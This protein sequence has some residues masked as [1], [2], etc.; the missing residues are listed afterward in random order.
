MFLQY[1]TYQC[2]EIPDCMEVLG[3]YA[4]TS[5]F[6]LKTVYIPESVTVFGE[7]IFYETDNVTI[8]GIS[9]SEAEN[10]AAQYNIPFV[11]GDMP[12]G[13]TPDPEPI[14]EGW[15]EDKVGWWYQ[16][17][18]GT[19]PKN[20]WKQIY[21]RWYHFDVNGYM[22]TGWQKF[23]GYRYYLGT[24]GA[25]SIGWKQ[26]GSKWYYFESSGIMAANKWIAGTYY[27]K[28]DGSMAVNEWV[29]GKYY[30]DANGKWI[31]KNKRRLETGQG[32]LVE[33][34]MLMEHTRQTAGSR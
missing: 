24:D 17:A 4:F 34:R 5:T 29:D 3:D 31:W 20:T 2:L 30:V 8:Y 22:Q 19:Y 15:R 6:N 14:K 27:M 32:R 13:D 7:D 11:D 21:G 12:N 33:S 9:G 25:M 23:G 10:Y 16:N 18:D 26:I 1:R 28:A